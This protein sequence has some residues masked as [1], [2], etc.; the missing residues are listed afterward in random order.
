MENKCDGT[1]WKM[2]KRLTS[3]PRYSKIQRAMVKPRY[4]RY[5]YK[6]EARSHFI[7]KFD[8]HPRGH[9]LFYLH[10]NK[11]AQIRNLDYPTKE[12]N[13]GPCDPP[14]GC[15][16]FLSKADVGKFQILCPKDQKDR[17]SESMSGVERVFG[18]I[19]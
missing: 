5:A 18:V 17:I 12:A 4:A 2:G 16:A 9:D 8:A 7:K 10:R 1:E 19:G 14:S 3:R 15:S 11:L 6:C 13:F